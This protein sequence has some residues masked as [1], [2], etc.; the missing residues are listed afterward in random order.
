VKKKEIEV[1]SENCKINITQIISMSK[2]KLSAQATVLCYVSD[3]NGKPKR[4][5]DGS[6]MYTSNTVHLKRKSEND[7]WRYVQKTACGINIVHSVY[8]C[9]SR[10]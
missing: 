3:E 10:I 1:T 8:Q 5:K 4:A 6:F 2:N 9:G 7:Y